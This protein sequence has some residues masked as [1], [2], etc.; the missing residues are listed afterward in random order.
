MSNVSI[1]PGFEVLI[2]DNLDVLPISD[3]VFYIARKINGKTFYVKD[4][5]TEFNEEFQIT[6]EDIQIVDTIAEAKIIDDVAIKDALQL[7]GYEIIIVTADLDV[8]VGGV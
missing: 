3:K 5:K 6:F 1:E 7:D 8:T 2:D 4:Y